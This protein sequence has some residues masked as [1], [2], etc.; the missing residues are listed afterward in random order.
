[1]GSVGYKEKREDGKQEGTCGTT[2]VHRD[3]REHVCAVGWVVSCKTYIR[4]ET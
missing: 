1:M 2:Y 3:G 4:G